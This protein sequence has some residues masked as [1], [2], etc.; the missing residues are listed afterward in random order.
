MP[1]ATRHSPRSVRERKT[2]KETSASRETS[3]NTVMT[4]AT[5]VPSPLGKSN[6]TKS[7]E[8]N[9]TV[10]DGVVTQEM[11]K[12]ESDLHKSAQQQSLADS[13]A[14]VI[15][16]KNA[17]EVDESRLYSCRRTTADATFADFD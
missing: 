17:I 11:I 16:P 4:P 2:S 10:S 7:E 13:S 8:E 14:Q 9:N 1:V 5:S 15:F 3:P 12:E 6:D